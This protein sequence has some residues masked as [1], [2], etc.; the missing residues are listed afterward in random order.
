M[1]KKAAEKGYEA[2]YG[3]T[4]GVV[5][6]VQDYGLKQSKIDISVN[7]VEDVLKKGGLVM[8]AGTGP[9][10]FLNTSHYIVIRKAQ[11]ENGTQQT[12]AVKSLTT[13]LMILLTSSQ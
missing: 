6:M 13:L 7:A 9:G 1:A 5:E 3:T 12:L 11:V 10:P 4:L 8:L 2:G